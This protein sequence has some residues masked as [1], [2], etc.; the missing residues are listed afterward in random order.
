MTG[1]SQR[2]IAGVET[3][4]TRTDAG[5]IP[6]VR[7][8]EKVDGCGCPDCRNIDVATLRRTRLDTLVWSLRL[9]RRYPSIPA[10]ALGFILVGRLI[11][12]ALA[13]NLPSPVIETARVVS[14]L[15]VG[16]VVRAHVSG[17]VAG[18]L[19][20]PSAEVLNALKLSLRRLPALAGV[21]LGIGA[22]F[23]GTFVGTTLISFP[24]AAVVFGLEVVPIP[25]GGGFGVIAGGFMLVSVLPILFVLFKSWF[26]IEACVVGRH[27]PIES[28]RVSWRL[29]SNHRERL[30]VTLAVAVGSVVGS[31][32]LG[33]SVGPVI[34]DSD[35]I[36]DAAATD[37]GTL[38]SVVWYGVF[39]HLYVQ[40]VV[41]G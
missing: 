6:V 7:E 32:L 10:L 35:P 40:G 2:T 38:L 4:V 39:A 36:L 12:T 17:I 31:V 28:L 34:A 20:G 37:L 15:G 41:E 26:A 11:Q 25:T 24:L 9:F 8:R 23:V 22:L 30:V 33:S 18:D 16:I 19:V 1:P 14:G 13:P 27:D 29:T 21:V 5:M 3:G